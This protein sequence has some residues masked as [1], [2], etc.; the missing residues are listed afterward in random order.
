MLAWAS[1]LVVHV[2]PDGLPE[3]RAGD[4]ILS[5]GDKVVSSPRKIMQILMS[6][7][8]G[9]SVDLTVMRDHK[10]VDVT[11]QLSQSVAGLGY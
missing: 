2:T 8:Q 1:V 6:F 9:D 5:C 3:L 4:V 10:V 7:E 11:V